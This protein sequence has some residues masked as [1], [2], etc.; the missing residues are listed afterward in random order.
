MLPIH[1]EDALDNLKGAD[2]VISAADFKAG[3]G[4]VRVKR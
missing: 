4:V 1:S 3:V 2:D